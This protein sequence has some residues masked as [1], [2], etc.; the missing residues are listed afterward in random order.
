MCSPSRA[1]LFTGVYPAE[2]GVTLTLT[3]GRP[4]PDPKNAPGRGRG[5]WCDLCASR[6]APRERL[7]QAASAAACSGWAEA[8]ATRP[9]LPAGHPEPGAILLRAAGYEVAYK[10]KWHLTHPSGEK[11][12]RACSAAGRTATRSG[13]TRDYGF[14]DWVP[15]D[16]GENAKAEN[17][18][19]GNAGRGRG[20]GRGLHPPGRELARPREPAGAVLPGRLAGQPA[21]RARLPGL[22]RDAAATRPP[23]SATS[24]SSCRRPS[25]RTCAASR[26]STR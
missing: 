21:R 6:A 4:A 17:F 25:T 11:A 22:L 3:A 19:G 5:R 15:P 8:P 12:A 7:L 23:S 13:S 26:S 20:L 18:G 1:T 16:A 10:G 9:V 14:A 2:H 24:A